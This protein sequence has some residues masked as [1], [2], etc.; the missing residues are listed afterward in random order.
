MIYMIMVTVFK[1]AIYRRFSITNFAIGIPQ[2]I[3]AKGKN[4]NKFI[5]LDNNIIQVNNF[6]KVLINEK[7]EIL[8]AQLHQFYPMKEMYRVSE[9][10]KKV[11]LYC[12]MKNIHNVDQIQDILE[13]NNNEFTLIIEKH[14]DGIEL[15]FNYSDAIVDDE[16]NRFKNIFMNVL[17]SVIEDTEIALKDIEII[18]DTEKHKLLVDFNDTSLFYVKNK[19]I[20]KL[21]EEQAERT[22]NN[23]A[24]V[25]E[26]K[27]N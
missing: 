5:I 24:V 14:I 7:K 21:F 16:V 4:N 25:F 6:K 3:K 9:I 19:T 15:S 2:Y 22:P 13:L 23:I 11:N 8:E 17:N 27:K 12:C 18:N 26:G 20:N 10:Y 1:I